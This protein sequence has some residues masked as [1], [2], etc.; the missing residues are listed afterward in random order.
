MRS[1]KT[2]TSSPIFL[3]DS[4][5]VRELA[6]A[7][8]AYADAIQSLR[9]D[10]YA[11]LETGLSDAVLDAA[12]TYTADAVIKQGR[13]ADG[14]TRSDAIFNI[15]T[16]AP[17]LHLLST[18][19]GRRAFP[20]QTLNFEFGSQQSAHAD[21]YHFNA[22]P[23]GFMCGVWV[24]LEDVSADAGP[25]YYYP[26]S[27]RLASTSRTDLPGE[28]T[29][30]DYEHHM[31]DLLDE[32]GFEPQLA[33]LK[34]GQAL[35]WAANLVHGGA[36]RKNPALTRYSQVTHYYFEGCAYFTPL[37]YDLVRA[38]HML[39]NPYDISREQFVLS[40]RSL[41]SG[42]VN[43]YRAARRRAAYAKA[44]LSRDLRRLIDAT[45]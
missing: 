16:H 9:T 25:V 35:I 44:K 4:P 14:W 18:L 17:I 1:I 7:H 30:R 6:R 20:F 36:Q 5:E 24:A 45:A 33:V 32:N 8:P 29:Y 39:R 2:A 3:N 23:E 26:G 10:G 13:I 21:S 15:A 40:N 12:R 34:K 41:L 19:Y 42:R 38:Q 31:V 27:H 28:R 37:Q 11:I 22:K 43:R